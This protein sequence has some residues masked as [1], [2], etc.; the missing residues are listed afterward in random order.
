MILFVV[1]SASI[2]H[3]MEW[4]PVE[5]A[6]NETERDYD[7]GIACTVGFDTIPDSFWFVLVTMTSVGYGPSFAAFFH[8]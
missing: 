2:C 3:M 4:D 1:I 6:K 8:A 5:C 7:S